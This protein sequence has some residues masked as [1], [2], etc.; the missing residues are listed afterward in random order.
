LLNFFCLF[1]LFDW[2][3]I[4]IL[5]RALT[6]GVAEKAK[7]ATPSI[8]AFSDGNRHKCKA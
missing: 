3:E 8:F 4:T 5:L 2:Q 7:K 1:V 6:E